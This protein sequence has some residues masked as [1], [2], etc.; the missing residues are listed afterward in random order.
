MKKISA[1]FNYIVFI[2][3]TIAIAGVFYEGMTLKWYDIVGIFV[4]IMD[5]SFLVSTIINI[6]VYRKT[7]WLYINVFSLLCII[8]AFTLK[9][10]NVSYPVA[11]LVFW[12]FY[13]WFF[14]G[15]QITKRKNEIQNN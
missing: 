2:A 9:V 1:I 15:I 6:V 3:A 12:Y 8:L 13:I 4:L 14:Y 10:L 11:G 5:Y 7:K